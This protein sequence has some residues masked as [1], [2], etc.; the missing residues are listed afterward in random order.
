MVR[1]CEVT[2][3]KAP[4]EKDGI[5]VVVR[6][7]PWWPRCCHRGGRPGALAARQARGLAACHL[8]PSLCL[9]TGPILS[10]WAFPGASSLSHCLASGAPL[11]GSRCLREG[12]TWQGPGEALPRPWGGTLGAVSLVP[13]C[14]DWHAGG[15]W[16]SSAATCLGWATAARARAPALWDGLRQATVVKVVEGARASGSD[17]PA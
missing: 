11:P 5:T 6:L 14:G 15:R 1:V 13:G 3:D 17:R 9:G 4:L 10:V 12:A 16:D 7:R 2:Y 8:P